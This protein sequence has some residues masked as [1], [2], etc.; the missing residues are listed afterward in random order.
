MRNVIT[1]DEYDSGEVYNREDIL[2]LMLDLYKLDK[3]DTYVLVSQY[4][5]EPLL[6]ELAKYCKDNGHKIV[7]GYK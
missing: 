6:I 2:N 5:N 1:Q 3:N 7:A 4:G